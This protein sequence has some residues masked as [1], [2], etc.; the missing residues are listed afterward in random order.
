M[1]ISFVLPPPPIKLGCIPF[2]IQVSQLWLLEET[3]DLGGT[4]TVKDFP[5]L[6]VPGSPSCPDVLVP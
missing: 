6:W 3:P 2:N 1:Y 4:T 5:Y